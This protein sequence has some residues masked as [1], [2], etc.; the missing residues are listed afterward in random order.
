[1]A[2]SERL[3]IKEFIMKSQTTYRST[4]KSYIFW[5]LT[6]YHLHVIVATT[7]GRHGNYLTLLWQSHL[8]AVKKA[9]NCH[10][11]FASLLWQQHQIT[12][13]TTPGNHDNHTWLL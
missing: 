5:S 4:D 10:E 11:K 8:V 2:I 3:R 1:M 13:P 7:Q 12:I 9:P 6:Q